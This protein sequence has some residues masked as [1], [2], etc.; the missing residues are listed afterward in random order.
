[1]Y[2]CLVLEKKFPLLNKLNK[3]FF[4]SN[5]VNGKLQRAFQVLVKFN[6]DQ[7]I[8]TDTVSVENDVMMRRRLCAGFSKKAIRFCLFNQKGLLQLNFISRDNQIVPSLM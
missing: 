7:K 3:I 5:Q 1:M 4:V 6:K 2:H 8:L